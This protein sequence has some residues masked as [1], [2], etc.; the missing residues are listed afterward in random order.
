MEDD[1][2]AWKGEFNVPNILN[3]CTP[4]SIRA[5]EKISSTGKIV[6]PSLQL[7]S[8]FLPTL[9]AEKEKDS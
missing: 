3:F 1:R 8:F 7:H 6:C 9:K 2:S 4:F 5:H